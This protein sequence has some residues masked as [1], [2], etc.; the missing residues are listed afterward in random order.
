MKGALRTGRRYS[1]STGGRMRRAAG[2]QSRPGFTQ[3]ACIR[4]HRIFEALVQRGFC[5]TKPLVSVPVWL[6]RRMRSISPINS[7]LVNSPSSVMTGGPELLIR[8]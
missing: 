5:P 6:S 3:K 1:C 4:S 7:E 2:A 8:S